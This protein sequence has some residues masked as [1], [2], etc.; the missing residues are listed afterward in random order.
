MLFSDY[1]ESTLLSI[2]NSI[3]RMYLFICF[4]RSWSVIDSKSI[5]TALSWVA[6]DFVHESSWPKLYLKIFHHKDAFILIIWYECFQFNN[7]YSA[8]ATN[9]N[10][11]SKHLIRLPWINRTNGTFETI[12]LRC[13]FKTIYSMHK[14]AQINLILTFNKASSLFCK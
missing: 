1:L 13:F 8:Q 5:S 11:I 3:R 10:H 2:A 4:Y 14:S 9:S 12:I 7:V 6:K